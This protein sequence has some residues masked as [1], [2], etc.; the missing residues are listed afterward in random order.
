MSERIPVAVLG[1]GLTGLSASLELSRQGAR[2]RLFEREKLA[3]GHAVTIEEQGFRFD[4]TGHLLHLRDP[5]MQAL[6]EDLLR[7]EQYRRLQRRSAVFSHGV[8]TRYPFQA[9]TFGLPPEVA[10]ECLSGFLEAHFARDKPEPKSFEEYCKLH[11]GRGISRHFMLPYNSRLWGVAPSEIT[12]EWCQR[13]VPLPRLEDVLRGAIGA[14]P[15]ELGYNTSFLYPELGM[16]MFS[17][18]L[19]ARTPVELGRAPRSIDLPGRRLGFDDES[20]A[21]DVLVSSIP[22]PV[23]LRLLEPLPAE[24]ARAAGKLRSTHLH[25]LDLG[26]SVPNPNPYHWIYVPEEKYPFYRVGC[27]TH[28][29]EKLGP[30]GKSSLYVE[31]TDRRAP[32]AD[33]VLAEVVTGLRELG[34]LKSAQD[35][36]LC[37]LR[38]IEHA[39]VIY[40]HEHRSALDVIEPFLLAQRVIS[41]GRYGGWNYSSMEDALLMGQSAA[42]HA[43]RLLGT[44]P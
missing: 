35:I 4:R 10:L 25:Y 28:F 9:N 14:Q 31:L 26:L 27:Y 8:Y 44:G 21:F 34:L 43:L 38:T 37:R 12:S 40:D 20:V 33:R 30:P 39:Y 3:G 1:A 17:A 41:T 16:G 7:P 2:H 6:A 15:P 36:E 22:L 19:S 42:Q 32:N 29:S 24:V 5:R 13:F 23:L 18:A 11:F